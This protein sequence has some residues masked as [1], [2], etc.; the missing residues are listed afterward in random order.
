MVP[1]TAA[2]SKQAQSSPS[3]PVVPPATSC[4]SS[5]GTMITSFLEIPNWFLVMIVLSVTGLIISI[6]LYVT[7]NYDVSF[8]GAMFIAPLVAILLAGF[9][10]VIAIVILG[11]VC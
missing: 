2:F 8:T 1:V 6:M 5:V 7:S 11:A 10:F 4:S 9:I 3:A